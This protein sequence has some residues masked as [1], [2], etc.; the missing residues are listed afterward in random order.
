LELQLPV[1]YSHY[2]VF[3]N[4]LRVKQKLVEPDDRHLDGVR[5]ASKSGGTVCVAVRRFV[6]AFDK[7]TGLLEFNRKEECRRH[8]DAAHFCVAGRAGLLALSYLIGPMRQAG[9]V[10]FAIQKVVVMLP[11]EK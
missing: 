10:R 7:I 3:A 11:H 4:L 6:N 2:H 9:S 5:R 1:T 8:I